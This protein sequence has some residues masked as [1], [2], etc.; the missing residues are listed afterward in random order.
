MLTIPI[1]FI[2]LCIALVAY[3][4]YTALGQPAKFATDRK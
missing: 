3:G 2:T 4:G 1:R